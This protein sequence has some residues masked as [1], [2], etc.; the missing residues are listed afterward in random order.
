M[1][2][3]ETYLPVE[4][5]QQSHEPPGLGGFAQEPGGGESR[6]P[7]SSL[8]NSR[9]PGRGAVPVLSAPRRRAR[10]LRR[11]NPAPLLQPLPSPRLFKTFLGSFLLFFFLSCSFQIVENQPAASCLIGSDESLSKL[12]VSGRTCRHWSCQLSFSCLGF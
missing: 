9:P 2:V 7:A 1:K 3:K 11:K 8:F 5:P 6:T 10:R 4:P 12:Q